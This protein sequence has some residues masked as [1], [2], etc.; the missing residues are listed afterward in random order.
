MLLLGLATL[1]V[2]LLGLRAV[3]QRRW[4]RGRML[5][6]HRRSGRHRVR[7][8]ALRARVGHRVEQR[9]SCDQGPA[10]GGNHR[11]VDR[12]A[13]R[14]GSSRSRSGASVRWSASSARGD[15]AAEQ[16]R[17]AGELRDPPRAGARVRRVRSRGRTPVGLSAAAGGRRRP[18]PRPCRWCSTGVG[19][20]LACAGRTH[21]EQ[22]AGRR[23]GPGA[24]STQSSRIRPR[25]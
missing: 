22:E 5:C 9:G 13:G 8:V 21:D 14:R 10:P 6:A 2:A 1:G 16:P 17:G 20:G 11:R 23:V 25:W 18:D 19:R 24:V 4:G 15:R 3:L 12:I 7:R